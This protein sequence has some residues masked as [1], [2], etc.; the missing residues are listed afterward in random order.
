MSE[1]YILKD[2]LFNRETVTELAK[3][4]QAVH[5]PF[6]LEAFVDQC[7]EGFPT[8]E[9]KERMS[10]MTLCLH[11]HLPQDFYQATDILK[12]TCEQTDTNDRFVYGSFSEYVEMYGCSDQWVDHSLT[13]LGE[14]TKVFSAEF[15]IRKFINQYP[16]KALAQMHQWAKSKDHNQRRLASEGLRPKLP[17]GSGIN[18]DPMKAMEP[19]DFLYYD[20]ERYVTRSVANH[21]ND[22]SKIH[23]QV[24]I[25]T[26]ERW[27][28]TGR[29]NEKEMAYIVSHSTRTLVKRGHQGALNLLG[30]KTGARIEVEGFVIHTPEIHIGDSIVF[31]VTIKALEDCKLMVDYQVDYPMAKGK[32]GQKVFKLKKVSLQEG[33]SISMQKK[34][35]FKE[36]TT[37]KLYEGDHSVRLQI[38]GQF[39]NE[40]SFYLHV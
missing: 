20:S 14:Y 36:M 17:W 15:A 25:E 35:A 9:L 13:M 24:V 38:N 33:Q 21:L 5:G 12:Q 22:L 26:L 40:G 32:R 28:A 7:V 2:D 31:D 39:H 29:Q 6:D 16:D 3:A 18:L 10:H 11:D 37:K 30:Y 27:Q 23:P 34:H 4:I 8:R 1:P 19:L